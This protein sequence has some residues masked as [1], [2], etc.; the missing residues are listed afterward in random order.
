MGRRGTRHQ[1][2]AKFTSPKV[3]SYLVPR[4]NAADTE[5]DHSRIAAELTEYYRP[6]YAKKPTEPS[7]FRKALDTL[8]RGDRVQRPAADECGRNIA[9]SELL[10]ACAY[11]PTGKS[12]GPDRLPNKMYKVLSKIIAPILTEVI[13]ESAANGVLPDSMKQGLISVLYKKGDRKDPRNYRPITLLNNDYKIMMRVLTARMNKAVTQFVSRDQ[14][15]FVP[16]GFIAEN[17]MRLQLLHGNDCCTE[18]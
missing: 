18:P 12:P 14:N 6:L 13:N 8:T 4:P 7:A 17:I 2:Q 3:P 5:K 11:L 1:K 15:G 10:H 9:T 16:D